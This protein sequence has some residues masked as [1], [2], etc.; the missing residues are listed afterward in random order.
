MKNKASIFW[1]TGMSGVGKTTLA[2]YAKVKLI[3]NGVTTLIIDGDMVREKYDNKLG[4]GRKDVELN[5]LNVAKL[6]KIERRNY[7]V[8]IVPIISP[9][10]IVRKKVRSILSPDYHL[11]YIFAEIMTLRNRDTKGLYKKADDG[12]LTDLIG[13]SDSNPYD[14]PEEYDF[15][16]AEGV[17]GIKG[18]IISNYKRFL[19]YT[20]NLNHLFNYLNMHN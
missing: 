11:I 13:Y 4:F 1:C 6:C 14:I 12:E 10:D 17:G 15:V 2:D 20:L 18:N 19:I 16:N 3:K 5:N 8:I 7:N 9:I